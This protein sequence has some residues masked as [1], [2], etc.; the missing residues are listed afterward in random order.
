M[1]EVGYSGDQVHFELKEFFFLFRNVAVGFGDILHVEKERLELNQVSF[2]DYPPTG[3]VL[4]L[5]E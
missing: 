3:L 4:D 2:Q 5:D 1:A